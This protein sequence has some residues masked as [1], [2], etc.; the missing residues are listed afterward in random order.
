MTGYEYD[1]TGC[2]DDE[3]G[4]MLKQT[5]P[6]VIGSFQGTLVHDFQRLSNS[7]I[8]STIFCLL[9]HPSQEI[10]N[11]L[12]VQ[13]RRKRDNSSLGA[14]ERSWMR[15]QRQKIHTRKS[16]SERENK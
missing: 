5:S 13:K 2:K 8:F 7:L 3:G 11:Y 16:K 10:T 1:D 9:C 15:Y 6:E 14:K 4:L 12:A